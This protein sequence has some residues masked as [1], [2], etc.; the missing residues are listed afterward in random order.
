M[1][2]QLKEE[3]EIYSIT[4]KACYYGSDSTAELYVDN[5]SVDTLT[6]T[7][8][9]Y[10]FEYDG[11]LTDYFDVS[12]YQG[13]K[14]RIYVS[15]ITIVTGSDEPVPPTPTPTPSKS[16]CNGGIESTSI[17]LSILAISGVSILF[18]RKRKY[19]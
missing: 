9:D 8:T 5:Q 18:I 10:K 13:S 12:S 16:G 14:K 15:E 6:D 2:F 4:V 17:I 1:T 11:S 7:L 3:L 19:K